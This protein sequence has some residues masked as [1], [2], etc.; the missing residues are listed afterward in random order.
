MFDGRLARTHNAREVEVLIG[1]DDQF[2]M[3]RRPG[4][5]GIAMRQVGWQNLAQLFGKGHVLP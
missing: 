1:L 2:Q 5:T 3:P 4:D